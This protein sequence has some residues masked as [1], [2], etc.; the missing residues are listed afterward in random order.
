L[1]PA[2]RVEPASSND[3][4][5]GPRL[6]V[7]IPTSGRGDLLQDCFDSLAPGIDGGIEL[8]VVDDGRA[9]GVRTAC[10]RAPVSVRIV[11]VDRDSGFARAV[12]AGLD[13]ARAPLL[14]VLNN[15]VVA[16]PGFLE[17]LTEVAEATGAGIVVPRVL[18]L[19]DRR[20]VDNTGNGLYPDGLNL[21]R[22]RGRVDEPG[23]RAGVDP[24][25]PSGAAVLLRRALLERIGGFDDGFF[26]YGEDAELGMRALRAGYRCRY[27][28]DAVVYHLGGGT[29]GRSSLRKAYLV[30]RN[31]ARLARA[32]LPAARLAVAP[33]FAAA[34][35]LHHARSVA[36]GGGPLASY[37]QGL[38]RGGAAFAAVL[39]VVASAAG[40]PFDLR[41]R[42]ERSAQATLSDTEFD[43]LLD[44][45]MVGLSE[46]RQRRAW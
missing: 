22:A 45:R 39:A 1:T 37:P 16:A 46:V 31:R 29:W 33:L 6:S 13:A 19:R 25:L 38:A 42:R 43:A 17:R 3:P 32:H 44:E 21:C 4:E 14:L 26:A 23:Q 7:V 30:E 40:L 2:A 9:D 18:A 10:Q 5:H 36:E 15:D 8:I 27:A 20:R 24:L 41:R 11:P 28:P 12:N 35:Y 34:R